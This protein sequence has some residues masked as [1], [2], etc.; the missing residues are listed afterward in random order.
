MEFEI[1]KTK[2]AWLASRQN[3]MMGTDIA[4]IIGAHKYKSPLMIWA[5]KKQGFAPEENERMKWGKKMEPVIGAEWAERHGE[6]KTAPAGSYTIFYHDRTRPFGATLD[7]LVDQKNP[8]E[9]KTT[10]YGDWQADGVPLMYQ[11]QIQWQLLATSAEVA[12]CAALIGGNKY[13]ETEILRDEKFLTLAQEKALSWHQQ[14]II[15]DDIPPAEPT[16][17]DAKLLATIYGEFDAVKILDPSNAEKMIRRKDLMEKIKELEEEKTRL[18][19][20]I[21]QELQGANYGQIPGVEGYIAYK[22]QTKKSYTVKES[23][24]RVFRE[25]KN[26]PNELRQ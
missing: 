9:I 16:R 7:F 17:D 25:V 5:E 15:G 13:F 24:S 8:L 21:K 2:E 3:L 12:Y 10:G 20:E 22:N 4:A 26:L 6:R 14:Y 23:T 11:V 19:N 1:Y 18:E